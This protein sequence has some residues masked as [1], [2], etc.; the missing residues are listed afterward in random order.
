MAE[1]SVPNR[2]KL[3]TL[4]SNIDDAL[5]P[6]DTDLDTIGFHFGELEKWVA[7]LEDS[8]SLVYDRIIEVI[9]RVKSDDRHLDTDEYAGG[10][11]NAILGK[12]PKLRRS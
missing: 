11:V 10:I 6:G 12:K 9:D 1:T 3:T 2:D 4:M 5:D 8:N 7:D